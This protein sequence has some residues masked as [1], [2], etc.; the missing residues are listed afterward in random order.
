[1]LGPMLQELKATV[2]RRVRRRASPPSLVSP[3]LVVLKDVH[4]LVALDAIRRL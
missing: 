3:M 1:M 4:L 2:Q